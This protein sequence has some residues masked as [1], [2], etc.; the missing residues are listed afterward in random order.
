MLVQSYSSSDEN[1]PV[2]QPLWCMSCAEAAGGHLGTWL[3]NILER[4]ECAPT[5]LEKKGVGKE[6]ATG[7]RAHYVG[8]QE[9]RHQGQARPGRR[10]DWSRGPCKDVP[11]CLSDIK[12]TCDT[13]IRDLD[14]CTKRATYNSCWCVLVE[15]H[16]S[17][18]EK[19]NPCLEFIS[20]QWH[21]RF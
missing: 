3:G 6:M 7:K 8:K 13:H 16:K 10:V 11:E 9:S 17:T 2:T 19:K 21:K 15:R 5:T 18:R 1:M 4:K 12:G 14:I 20:T